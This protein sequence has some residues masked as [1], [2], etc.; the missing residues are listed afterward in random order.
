[1]SALMPL[2]TATRPIVVLPRKLS[3]AETKSQLCKEL[4]EIPMVSQLNHPGVKVTDQIIAMTMSHHCTGKVAA[5]LDELGG[6][7]PEGRWVALNEALKSIL[8]PA[9]EAGKE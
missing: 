6:G 9:I 1:M 3:T 2:R 5:M 7:S 8:E 4:A